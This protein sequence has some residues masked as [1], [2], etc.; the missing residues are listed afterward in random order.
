MRTS[1]SSMLV[2]I[3]SASSMGYVWVGNRNRFQ[4][5]DMY[6]G[7]REISTASLWPSSEE[8]SDFAPNHSIF[9]DQ[10][11][12]SDPDGSGRYPPMTSQ[13]PYHTSYLSTSISSENHSHRPRMMEHDFFAQQEQNS[14]FPSSTSQSWKQSDQDPDFS[15]R[16]DLKQF[17]SGY[18]ENRTSS[19]RN[20]FLRGIVTSGELLRFSDASGDD[21]ANDIDTYHR[22]STFTP[23]QQGGSENISVSEEG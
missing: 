23:V 3:F 1:E 6:L 2:F 15:G 13:N 17:V 8:F 22:K 4:S 5:S 21:S 16:N 9:A 20:D 14:G 7:N 19:Q 12:S 11:R 10:R 18:H